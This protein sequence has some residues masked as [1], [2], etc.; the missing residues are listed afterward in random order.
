MLVR[1]NNYTDPLTRFLPTEFIATY[2][3]VTQL[4]S[5]SVDLRQPLLLLSILVCL[6]LI[7]IFLWRKGINDIRHH[8]AVV[9]SFL[10]WVYA[11]GDAFQPGPWIPLDLHVPRV[12]GVL[13]VLWGLVSTILDIGSEEGNDNAG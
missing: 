6:V 10:L 11:L 1:K 8:L 12:A 5:D 4:V 2:L 3:G 9:L 13:M 7:P